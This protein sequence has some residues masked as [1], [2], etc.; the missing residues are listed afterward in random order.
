MH[1]IGAL[2][3]DSIWYSELKLNKNGNTIGISIIGHSFSESSIAKLLLDS[4]NIRGV[5]KTNL[6]YAEKL[7]QQQA[8]KLT[9]G[10][11]QC[12]LYRFKI[13]L[14]IVAS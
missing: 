13:I 1:D 7:S 12:E 5:T 10:R 9:S 11:L 14:N 6:E 2:A 4:Q 8:A 3:G